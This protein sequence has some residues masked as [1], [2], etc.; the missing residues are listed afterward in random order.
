ML[1]TILG[2]ICPGTTNSD[3]DVDALVKIKVGH[4]SA[5]ISYSKRPKSCFPSFAHFEHRKGERK[6]HINGLFNLTAVKATFC[7]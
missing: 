6:V 4:M 7:C 2:M 3:E 5:S 1:L